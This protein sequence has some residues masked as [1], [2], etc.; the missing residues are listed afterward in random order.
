MHACMCIRDLL[1]EARPLGLLCLK[2]GLEWVD[3]EGACGGG[4][5]VRVRARAE[6]EG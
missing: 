3:L 5:E 2:L 1:G 4:G 6:G